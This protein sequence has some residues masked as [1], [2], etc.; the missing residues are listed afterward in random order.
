MIARFIAAVA[1]SMTTLTGCS[2]TP[3]TGSTEGSDVSRQSATAT[4]PADAAP[5]GFPD[6]SAY[7]E[8]GEQ[9]AQQMVPRVQGFA[10]STPTGLICTSNAYPEPKFEHVGCRGPIPSQ[11]PGEWSVGAGYAEPGTI[12]SLAG[13]PDFAADKKRPP[14]TLAPMHKVTSLDGV[15]VCG[16][17]DAGTVACRIDDHGFVITPA[18]TKIF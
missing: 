4:S 13:D 12:E 10:F 15:A 8:S 18:E 17:D 9:F 16:V 14:P 6:L 3:D 5:A 7:T 2:P 1:L 11:G